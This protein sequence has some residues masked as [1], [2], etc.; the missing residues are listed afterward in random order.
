[1]KALVLAGLSA[2]A[3]LAAGCGNE[4]A[5]AP[6]AEAPAGE[7]PVQVASVPQGPAPVTGTVNWEAARADSEAQ[8]GVSAGSGPVGRKLLA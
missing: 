2:V 7:Q 1:M 8:P 6:V 4:K 5:P 3:L